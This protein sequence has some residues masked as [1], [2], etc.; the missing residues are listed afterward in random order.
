MTSTGVL[1]QAVCELSV[2]PS[3]LVV[4]STTVPVTGGITPQAP[5][6]PQ[7]ENMLD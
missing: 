6:D 2:P 3:M 5:I 7:N 1:Q 4:G